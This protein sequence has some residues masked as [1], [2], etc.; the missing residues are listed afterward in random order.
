MYFLVWDETRSKRYVLAVVIVDFHR[1]GLRSAFFKAR[2][3]HGLPDV[4]QEIIQEQ[5]KKPPQALSCMS[6]TCLTAPRLP[7]TQLL[8]R[9]SSPA[10]TH[11]INLPA[12]YAIISYIPIF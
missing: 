2:S 3:L 6:T 9:K 5:R 1:V 11:F 7:D 12:A 8:L 4:I 10:A